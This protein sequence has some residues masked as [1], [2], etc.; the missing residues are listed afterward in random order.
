MAST[1]VPSSP[2][3]FEPVVLRM[4]VDSCTF[5]PQTLRVTSN[6][7]VIRVSH[8]P[9]NCLV[10]GTP[11]V[12]DIRLGSLPAGSWRADVFLSGTATTAVESL[13]FSVHE[14]DTSAISP[15]P[16][17]PF[18]DHS[19]FWWS[20]AEGG[21]GLVLQQQALGSA[22]FGAWFIFGPTGGPEWYTVQAG[23]WTSN[24]RWT[25]NVYR[26]N[27]P[28]GTG[29]YDTRLVATQ[30]AGTATLDFTQ[31]PGAE[32]T[33]RFSYTLNGVSGEKA[34]VRFTGL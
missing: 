21:S 9:A 32:G 2:L 28:P 20:P 24:T 18:D 1:I 19:G 22:V 12:A 6:A 34:I 3:A 7:G 8:V 26:T 23:H 29:A 31:A 17:L 13:P 14:L 27:G 11:Q 4:A 10:A 33:A 16:L 15:P 30:L 25:G 5:Q